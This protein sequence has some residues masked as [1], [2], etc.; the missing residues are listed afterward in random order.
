VEWVYG[1]SG[2]LFHYAPALEVRAIAPEKVRSVDIPDG[3][4]S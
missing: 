3:L 2:A 4:S 1:E